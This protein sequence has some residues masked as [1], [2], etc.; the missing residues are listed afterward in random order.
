MYSNLAY[1]TGTK[2][3]YTCPV[4]SCCNFEYSDMMLITMLFQLPSHFNNLTLYW[5]YQEAGDYDTSV[6]S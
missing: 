3:S 4:L 5:I 1:F 2:D 6:L